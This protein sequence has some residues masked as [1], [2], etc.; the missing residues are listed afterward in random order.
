MLSPDVRLCPNEQDVAAKILDGEAIMINLANGTY[1]S[2]D[3]VGA[4]VWELL[5]CGHTVGQ[6][7]DQIE[8]R[9]EGAAGKAAS[10]I[11]DLLQ[12]MLEEKIVLQTDACNQRESDPPAHA[13]PTG[14][15]PYQPPRL[16][17]YRDMADLLAL[18]PPTP[19]AAQ[20]KLWGDS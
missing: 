5:D 14:M 17:I 18:E 6:V 9:F 2:L 13:P 19:G 8:Q 11:Q 3:K 4:V 16:Q 10:D 1:Y 20:E 15:L 7:V 12:A